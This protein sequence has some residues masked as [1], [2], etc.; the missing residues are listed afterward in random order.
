MQRSTMMQQRIKMVE[1]VNMRL[2][3]AKLS[4]KKK[5]RR[6]E[7]LGGIL[8]YSRRNIKMKYC[9]SRQKR[10]EVKEDGKEGER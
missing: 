9:R 1:R 4:A 5:T 10:G 8:Y 2:T 7:K 3:F 6:K